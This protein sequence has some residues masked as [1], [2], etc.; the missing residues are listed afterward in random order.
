MT[1]FDRVRRAAMLALILVA[2]AGCDDVDWFFMTYWGDMSTV[3]T[4]TTDP[5]Q[6]N[7]GASATT[8]GG[9]VDRVLKSFVRFAARRAR[10]VLGRSGVEAPDEVAAPVAA[11]AAPAVRVGKTKPHRRRSSAGFE[12]GAS[13]RS[14]RTGRP[15]VGRTGAIAARRS[16]DARRT[17]VAVARASPRTPRPASP[18]LETSTPQFVAADAFEI[19]LVGRM[20]A[21]SRLSEAARSDGAVAR[22]RDDEAPLSATAQRRR[23]WRPWTSVA[24]WVSGAAR[25]RDAD[26]RP[27]AAATRPRR[28]RASPGRPRARRRRPSN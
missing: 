16:A 17:D 28:R 24:K 8:S 9:Q 23:S 21:P 10:A 13:F 26:S 27:A 18:V 4:R 14:G 15:F 5:D 6:E 7:S 20:A 19:A 25:R 2:S 12:A 3:V 22:L 11:S 1:T